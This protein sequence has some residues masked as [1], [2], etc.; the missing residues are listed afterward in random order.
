MYV[1]NPQGNLFSRNRGRGDRR[2]DN[3]VIF[4][5]RRGFYDQVYCQLNITSCLIHRPPTAAKENKAE[6]M[7]ERTRDK[8]TDIHRGDLIT[9]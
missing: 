7:A 9:R 1:L 4:T 6:T 2:E 3:S 8:A 5:A